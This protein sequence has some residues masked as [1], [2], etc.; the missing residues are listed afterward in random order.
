MEQAVRRYLESEGLN[1]IQANYHCKMG[2]IDLI[3]S[4]S[5][6]LVFVEVRYRNDLKFC[7]PLE[8]VTYQKQRKLVRTASHYLVKQYQSHDIA[9]RFDVVG[10]TQKN[11]QLI[12]DWIKNAFY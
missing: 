8:T 9:C 10:V 5:S 7:N 1:F 12:F 3:M 2:E 11:E 6:S 4:D